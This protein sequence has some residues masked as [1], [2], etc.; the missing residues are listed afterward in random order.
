MQLLLISKKNRLSKINLD[1]ILTPL[2]L[3]I[4][5][6]LRYLSLFVI[7]C[8]LM[9]AM[10]HL[11]KENLK[12]IG[13]IQRVKHANVK[14]EGR[15][16]G[17]IG[18]GLL[19]LVCTQT[20]DT[21]NTIDKMLSKILQMR[22]FS[23]SNGKMNNSLQNMDGNGLLGGLLIVSQFTLA[24]DIK[25]GNRP[26]FTAAAPPVL[27]QQLFNAFVEKAREKHPFVQTGVFG[28]DMQVELIN[29]GPVT[30]PITL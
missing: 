9:L 25:S 11:Q 21:P 15:I 24:A 26:G 4:L 28:A 10:G 19:L 1:S 17:E 7:Y 22:I 20:Q 5:Q 23:D 30:I 16:V 6:I 18:A 29:D 27:A 14:I 12:M 2:Q 13:L 8:Y 3:S